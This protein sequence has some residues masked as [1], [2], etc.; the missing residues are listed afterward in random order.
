MQSTCGYLANRN[1]VELHL[2]TLATTSSPTGRSFRSGLIEPELDHQRGSRRGL[3]PCGGQQGPPA[4][5]EVLSGK[6]NHCA[7]QRQTGAVA[8]VGLHP[9][10]NQVV[11]QF[12]N[13]AALQ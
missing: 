10:Q 7:R 2:H 1:R 12:S 9:N 3:L 13:F 6:A 5:G 8:H 11:S 4:R